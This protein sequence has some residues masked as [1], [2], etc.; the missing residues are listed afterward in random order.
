MLGPVNKIVV[1]RLLIFVIVFFYGGIA[2][3][4]Q[5]SE[6]KIGGLIEAHYGGVESN[7]TVIFKNAKTTKSGQSDVNGAYSLFLP[8]GIYEIIVKRA[9]ELRY[10]R[11][12]VAIPCPNNLS[13]N[14][15]TLPECVSY[16]C[17]RQGFDFSSF[18]YSWTKNRS[19]DL[20]IAYNTRKKSKTRIEYN[21]AMLTYD[22][23]TLSADKI[24][25][26]LR[27]ETL[28]AEGK[29]WIEDGNNRQ[30]FDKLR[31]TFNSDGIQITNLH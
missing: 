16:G 8:P 10:K 11:A 21:D 18:L 23:Y 24:V 13:I 29:G 15:Y 4:S 25:Q 3:L 9:S 19:L 31:L 5:P 6:C 27:S 22:K 20:L 14:I 30:N 1:M 2:C 7:A 28:I 26:N 17:Q 12:L